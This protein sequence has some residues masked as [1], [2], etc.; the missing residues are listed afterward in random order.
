MLYCYYFFPMSCLFTAVQ[1]LKCQRTGCGAAIF[2]FD[3]CFAV[4]CASCKGG[5]C[6]WYKTLKTLF[7]FLA[8]P[9]FISTGAWPI[10]V[11][12]L[13]NTSKAALSACIQVRKCC[14][15]QFPPWM[16][17]RLIPLS[18][19]SY[20]GKLTEFNE[21]HGKRRCRSVIAY[22]QSIPDPILRA[23]VNSAA[24]IIVFYLLIL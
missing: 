4:T 18:S 19:G 21:V 13:T 7:L 22:L 15:Q 24:G 14:S 20:H 8:F 5:F 11:V 23:A 1:M 12:M 6:A 2:D 3:G 17:S 9:W 16:F 10:A